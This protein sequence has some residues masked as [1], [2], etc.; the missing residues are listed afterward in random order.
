V[1]FGHCR[2]RPSTQAIINRA[3]AAC[4]GGLKTR[5][6]PCG[7]FEVY[8]AAFKDKAE[9]DAYATQVKARGLD[10]VVERN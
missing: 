7:G 5:P 10:V 3:A 8:L 9:A 6:D 2:E 1:I 4:I